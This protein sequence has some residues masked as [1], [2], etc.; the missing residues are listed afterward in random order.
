MK[1]KFKKL[2]I[3]LLTIASILYFMA[4]FAITD[5]FGFQHIMTYSAAGF[6]R[7]HFVIPL[8]ILIFLHISLH[9]S[10]FLKK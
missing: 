5:K 7:T 4:E 10:D 8:M 6:I 2:T 9:F 1:N 3:W